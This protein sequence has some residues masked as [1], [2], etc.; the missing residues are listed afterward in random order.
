MFQGIDVTLEWPKHLLE[1]AKDQGRPLS[2]EELEA[3]RLAHDAEKTKP[4][5]GN[6]H[7]KI[8]MVRNTRIW[9]EPVKG[10][11][12]IC[13][14]LGLTTACTCS[15]CFDCSINGHQSSR[16]WKDC[17][18][19]ITEYAREIML[20]NIFYS[21][22]EADVKFVNKVATDN[23]LVTLEQLDLDF[24]RLNIP[25]CV[26]GLY[27]FYA[28]KLACNCKNR[29]MNLCKVWLKQ[30]ITFF[31][32]VMSQIHICIRLDVISEC[33]SKCSARSKIFNLMPKGAIKT[34]S[35]SLLK[36]G[37]NFIP[38]YKPNVDKLKSEMDVILKT[39]L[40]GAFLGITGEHVVT[41]DRKR[42]D[43][44]KYSI[45]EILAILNL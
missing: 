30:L 3:A 15:R 27:N 2:V 45:T 14:G 11:H 17:F 6:A 43:V 5:W 4:K 37:L 1:S 23:S 22:N 41:N 7:K 28:E 19:D 13:D 40:T 32:V 35:L 21:H 29:L 18:K 16:I 26:N 12:R 20:L 42:I 25:N 33:N 38:S 9:L 31:K 24:N 10:S 36:K 39:C 44:K 8:S 34:T